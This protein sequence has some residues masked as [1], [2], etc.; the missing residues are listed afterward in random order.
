[1]SSW[2]NGFVSRGQD[3]NKDLKEIFKAKEEYRK[4]EATSLSFEEKV[5]IVGKLQQRVFEAKRNTQ[6]LEVPTPPSQK[7]SS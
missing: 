1:M 7:K 3:V 5:N 6:F 4:A 2:I